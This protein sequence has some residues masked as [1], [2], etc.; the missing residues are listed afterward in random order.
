MPLSLQHPK[1]HQ[2]AGDVLLLSPLRA[3]LTA[4][5]AALMLTDPNDLLNLRSSSIEAAHLH[6]RSRQAVGG[7]GVGAVSDDHHC[8]PPTQATRLRPVRMAPRGPQGRAVART[9]LL[10]STDNIPPVVTT[11][12]QQSLGGLPGVTEDILRVTAEMMARMAE[13]RQRQRILRGSACAPEPYSQGHS[14]RPIGPYQQPQRKA[15]D[16]PTFR[17]GEHPCKPLKS[18]GKGVR[19]D[20]SVTNAIATLPRDAWAQR[21]IQEGWPRPIGL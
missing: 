21:R 19:H 7:K 20:C 4:A 2:T 10:Q 17:A 15:G 14:K 8:E 3:G 1:G 5:E 11:P 13:P 6:G 18:R 12:F 16:G 9:V